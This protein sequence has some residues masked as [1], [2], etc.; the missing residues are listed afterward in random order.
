[1]LTIN[2]NIPAL[3]ASN[4]LARNQAEVNLALERLSTGLRIN[5]AKDDAAGLAI[6]TRM[7]A[8]I[9]G[10]QVA[11][12]NASDG[13]SLAQTAEGALNEITNNLQRVRDLALQSANATNS[14]ADRAA[15]DDEVQ[16]RLEE[17]DRIARQT[18]FNGINVLDGSQGE[19]TFQVGANVGNTISLNLDSGA[20]LDQMG[21]FAEGNLA[22]DDSAFTDGE[23]DS[24]ATISITVGDNEPREITFEAGSTIEDMVAAIEDEEVP[25]LVSASVQDGE[26]RLSAA[27]EITLGGDDLETVFDGPP[28]T[29]ELSGSLEG[30]NVRTVDDANATILR[31]DD[32]LDSVNGLRSQ[33]GAIQNRFES[34]INNLDNSIENLSASRSR[35]MDADFA[36]ETA[37]LARA[38][39]MEQAA[40]A[41]LAQANAR[42][43]LILSLLQ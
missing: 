4:Q 13:V 19:L 32:A 16:Q 8:Q 40:I 39:V 17:V 6:A 34:T 37:R 28:E 10:Q 14:A 25:G 43:Q 35:I 30:T 7:S 18:G 1:M 5:S 22:L 31:I 2:T 20:R 27:E 11:K 15:L 33:L 29:L 3:K 38:S 12:R 23:L 26:I 24:A 36:A 21:Q 41:V 9:S 42:N